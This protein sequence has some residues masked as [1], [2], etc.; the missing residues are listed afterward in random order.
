V[1]DDDR[2]FA[3]DDPTSRM[4]AA[5]F[6]AISMV[7]PSPRS[8]TLIGLRYAWRISSSSSP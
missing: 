5:A 1:D 6:A 8:Q 3:V 4:I 2:C 7:N